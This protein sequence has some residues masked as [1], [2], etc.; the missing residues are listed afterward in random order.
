M[1]RRIKNDLSEL[2]IAGRAIDDFVA[3][4]GLPARVAHELNLALDE[5]LTNIISY[6]YDDDQDERSIQISIALADDAITV[7]VEDDGRPFNPLEAPVEAPDP[8]ASIEDRRIGGLGIFLV[9]NMMDQ[10][11]YRRRGDKNTLIMK[12]RVGS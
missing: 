4:Q 1:M 2:A 5:V 7:E 10:L 3:C 9:R 11:E 8:L 12:K 6:G